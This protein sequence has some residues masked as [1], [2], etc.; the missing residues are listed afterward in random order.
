M[1]PRF[2][3]RVVKDFEHEAM[4]TAAI[5]AGAQVYC[6]KPF[7]RTPAEGDR[8]LALAAAR[9]VKIGVAHV[10]RAFGALAG[11]RALVDAGAIGRLRLLRAFGKCDRRGGGQDLFVLET[12]L[13]DLMRYFAGDVKW[14]QAHVTQDGHD[15]TRADVRAGDEGIGPVAG[16]GVVAYYAFRSGVA[17]E[18]ESLAA[19]DGGASA[20]SLLL[21]GT[22]GSLGIRSHPDRHLFRCDRA[23]LTPAS[24]TRWEP[25]GLPGHVPEGLDDAGGRY[26]WA[27]QR[28]IRDVLAAADEDRAP[29]A[30]GQ[31]AV[32]ALEMIMAAYEAHFAGRRVP[33]PLRRREHPLAALLLDEA[34][35]ALRDAL[36]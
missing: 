1:V 20:F 2:T 32:A 13:L 31:D 35:V 16:N 25:L 28:L 10:S 26:I 21:H 15:A 3:A 18:F 29:L 36:S 14:A 5:E 4:L 8:V 22:R 30:G 24:E 27:H 19:E 17:G 7:V 23:V 6:E 33:F 12:H 9:G 11:I 34:G